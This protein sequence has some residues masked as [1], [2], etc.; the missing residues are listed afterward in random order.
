[1]YFAFA[2]LVR[3]KYLRIMP[4]YLKMN[5]ENRDSGILENV[6]N[7]FCPR[8]I[9]LALILWLF[10]PANNQTMY[11]HLIISLVVALLMVIH[12]GAFAQETDEIQLLK[13]QLSVKIDDTT[14]VNIYNKLAS[15]YSTS[16]LKKSEQFARLAL[17][18]STKTGYRKGIAYANYELA[19]F[20]THYDFTLAESFI[21]TALD[22]A[23]NTGDSLLMAKVRNLIG[24]TRF[25]SNNVEG[26]MKYYNQALDYYLRNH[27]DSLAAGTYQNMAQAYSSQNKDSL[28]IQYF[29]KAIEINQKYNNQY[30][31]AINYLNIGKHYN[32][33]AQYDKTL[34]Y[35]NKSLEI[36]L[37]NNFNTQLP[38]L[39]CHLSDIYLQTG[40][41]KMAVQY[42][43][44][45]L[46]LAKKANSRYD[47]KFAYIILSN[48][49]FQ[50]HKM[51][52]AYYYQ[53]KLG[54]INDSIY[55]SERTE[56]ID[57]LEIKY[58]Y[59]EELKINKLNNQRKQI[60]LLL[61]IA[62]LAGLIVT[63]YLSYRLILRKKQL[64]NE[65]LSRE[66]Q[67]LEKEIEMKSREVTYKLLQ[68]AN[69]NQLI[70]KVIDT[71][72]TNNESLPEND[73]TF[74][75]VI[76]ELRLH[77]KFDLW[78]AFEK[79]FTQLHP[80]FFSN[81]T[82]AYPNLTQY[83]LRLSAFL[84]L[85][86]NSKEIADIMHLNAASIMKARYRLRKKLNFTDSDESLNSFFMKF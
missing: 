52:S 20:F 5:T 17:D 41:L 84:K 61:I 71:L 65:R 31:L 33:K 55:K 86:M 81:L 25:V 4:E 45:A 39:Y 51:D 12:F 34:Q 13:K 83:E 59:Q 1:M 78:E 7:G 8:R 82:K 53:K 21:I 68:V 38:F 40:D 9:M 32:K 63:I 57:M 19:R 60:T 18:L 23:V 6:G 47:L 37:A 77:Q 48:I 46:P 14:K 58:K 75:E 64:E 29:L 22:E 3:T 28:A 15:Y 49:Y 70:S 35:F 30:W 2:P 44:L 10:L 85:N 74:G 27:Q 76:S 42:A 26:A 62:I 24:V 11:R 73:S 80:N 50:Q 69:Q 66:K 72:T 16:E 67:L 56:S 79:E 36:L 43:K 54:E